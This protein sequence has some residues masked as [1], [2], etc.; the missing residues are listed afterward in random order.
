MTAKMDCGRI[1][2]MRRDDFWLAFAVGMAALA[3]FECW[4]ILSLLGAG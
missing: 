1:W 4:R 2:G 3:L